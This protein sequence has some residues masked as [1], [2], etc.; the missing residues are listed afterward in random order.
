MKN[1][2]QPAPRGARSFDGLTERAGRHELHKRLWGEQE[3]KLRKARRRRADGDLDEAPQD[4]Q[5]PGFL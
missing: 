2:D 3:R 1:E 5:E 4:G